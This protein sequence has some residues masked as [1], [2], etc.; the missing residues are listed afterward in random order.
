MKAVHRGQAGAFAT[1]VRTAAF[2][3]AAPVCTTS[4]LALVY[5]KSVGEFSFIAE[6]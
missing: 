5:S 1:L 6:M 4:D 2:V 3:T